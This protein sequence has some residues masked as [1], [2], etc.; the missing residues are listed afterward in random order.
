MFKHTIKQSQVLERV[1]LLLTNLDSGPG[2]DRADAMHGKPSL[3]PKSSTALSKVCEVVC[4][5]G[6][7]VC[8]G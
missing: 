1:L 7:C 4:T 5:V 3:L 6:L 2:A 8:V